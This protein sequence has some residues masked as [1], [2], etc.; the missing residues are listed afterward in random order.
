MR[1][2]ISEPREDGSIEV[3]LRI[4]PG[5]D[6]PKDFTEQQLGEFIENLKEHWRIQRALQENDTIEVVIEE[7]MVDYNY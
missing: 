3:K 2:E 5:R 7:E 6:Y 1:P 4:A